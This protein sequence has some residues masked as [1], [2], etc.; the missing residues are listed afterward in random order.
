[1]SEHET[2]P[3]ERF[4]ALYITSNE[5]QERMGV[6]RSSILHARQRGML[7]DPIMVRGVNTFIWERDGIEEYLKSWELSL[8]SRRGELN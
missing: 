6:V 2:T 8:K 1:M 5:I 3:Q 4:D 7:P